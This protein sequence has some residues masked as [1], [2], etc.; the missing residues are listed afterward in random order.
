MSWRRFNVLVRCLSPQ[1]ATIHKLQSSE[2]LGQKGQPV[3]VE[4]SRNVDRWFD[5]QFRK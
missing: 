4:G 3:V 2:F 1:S 5:S